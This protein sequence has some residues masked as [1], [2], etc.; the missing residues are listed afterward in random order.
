MDAQKEQN[1]RQDLPDEGSALPSAGTNPEGGSEQSDLPQ[2]SMPTTRSRKP[3]KPAVLSQIS[4]VV[5]SAT[6]IVNTAEISELDWLAAIKT[7]I[8]NTQ[9][10]G[11]D[12]DLKRYL[13]DAKAIRDGRKDLLH[14]GDVLESREQEWL[15]QGVIMRQATNLL[16]AAPKVGKTRLMLAA[17]ANFLKGRGEFAGVPLF[18][19]PE[20]LLLLGPDQSQRSWCSYLK[21]AGLVG[22]DNKLPA[23]VVGMVTAETGF[24][25]DEYWMAKIEERLREHG[26]LIVLLD[27]YS[28]AIRM[29]A[30][31]ENKAEAAVPMQQL[32]NLVMAY[33]STL[34][35][36]HHA[37]KAGGDG[38]VTKAARGS[39]AITAAVDNLIEMRAW[40]DQ[41]EPGVKKY[42]LSIS[43]RAETDGAP[44]IG[45]SKHSEEWN[46]YGSA[47]EAKEGLRKDD[48]YDGLTVAQLKT[49]DV[50]VR[51]LVDENKALTVS[52]IAEA[53]F[54]EVTKISKV[55]VSKQLNRLQTLGLAEHGPSEQQGNRYKQNHWKPTA[56]AVAKHEIAL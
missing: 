3:S 10:K 32:H 53:Q 42:E 11:S 54:E 47:R 25:L 52:E 33:D 37:N 44:L 45:Y 12:S 4:S 7:E 28:A 20:R 30:L 40:K 13:A 50:L 35:V 31:D 36:I 15:W 46:S 38:N 22:D 56:W 48:N 16:F 27:S 19:G 21:K 24:T 9:Y 8:H 6:R 55:A 14:C 34:I 23:Q 49:L 39:S 29:R 43:G 18:P 17:L 1:P 2:N 51:A 26:P 5:A 41:E